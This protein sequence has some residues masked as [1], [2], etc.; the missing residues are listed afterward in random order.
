MKI[1]DLFTQQTVRMFRITQRHHSHRA[2]GCALPPSTVEKTEGL[3]CLMLSGASEQ[4]WREGFRSAH[5]CMFYRRRQP[6]RM[7]KSWT[8]EAE[9]EALRF[10]QVPPFSEGSRARPGSGMDVS[11][12]RRALELSSRLVP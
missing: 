12:K 4:Q 5:G 9:Y 2:G 8:S 11:A 1:W 6:G 10:Q 7:E 3:S